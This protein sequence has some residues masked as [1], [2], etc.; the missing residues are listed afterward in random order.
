MQGLRIFSRSGEA[1]TSEEI[2]AA[3][4]I[5]NTHKEMRFGVITAED[6]VSGV[7][8][9]FHPLKRMAF[10]QPGRLSYWYPCNAVA[11]ITYRTVNAM[12][13]YTDGIPEPIPG[14][15]W[16]V[17]ITVFTSDGETLAVLPG[18]L[19]YGVA[20]TFG[21]IN[22]N[23][24]GNVPQW[25]GGGYRYAESFPASPLVI[26][27]FGFTIPE[28]IAMPPDG[29]FFLST[30]YPL[31][32]DDRAASNERLRQYILGFS[33]TTLQKLSAGEMEPHVAKAIKDAHPSLGM[34]AEMAEIITGNSSDTV[35]S[36]TIEEFYA[37]RTIQRTVNLTYLGTD[38]EQV[39]ISVT[40]TLKLETF[41]TDAMNGE[42]YFGD[43]KATYTDFP[44]F[45]EDPATPFDRTGL[46]DDDW[47]Y[48]EP[49]TAFVFGGWA[50][51][52]KYLDPDYMIQHHEATLIESRTGYP[53]MAII[54]G[55]EQDNPGSLAGGANGGTGIQYTGDYYSNIESEYLLTSQDGVLFPGG[56]RQVVKD[57][58]A[59]TNH[60]YIVAYREAY[61]VIYG[62][63]DSTL[64][65][66]LTIFG[67]SSVDQLYA[68][69][70]ASTEQEFL[71][72]LGF[73]TM[74]AAINFLMENPGGDP[75]KLD[76]G[77]LN[78]ELI[79]IYPYEGIKRDGLNYGIYS[80]QY[81]GRHLT[82][83][84]VDVIRFSKGYTFRYSFSTGEYT[85]VRVKDIVDKR[86]DPPAVA[87]QV[88]FDIS[89]LSG[90]Q[91]NEFLLRNMLVLSSRSPTKFEESNAEYRGQAQSIKDDDLFDEVE[92]TLMG[93]Y[94]F[95]S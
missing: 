82:S 61:G 83:N 40:G 6:P 74:Q 14:S 76:C 24:V 91:K 71:E 51:R 32:D 20:P 18:T 53:L 81:T 7:K 52:A 54:N 2:S 94:D 63:T 9:E 69:Y 28:D 70:G 57:E 93:L 10:T 36:E 95:L 21:S 47:L 37:E 41:A 5:S 4:K 65:Q 42:G 59:V 90:P 73:Y 50:F 60:P 45:N 78:G 30:E 17:D 84:P 33:D 55:T 86:L 77:L 80:G 25:S 62:G 75:S 88:E 16:A 67:F 26:Q 11:R 19:E 72:V 44:A 43:F 29:S 58:I 64:A 31:S 34:M 22:Y 1:L 13:I 79:T 35:I 89:E 85:F 92:L 66:V 38:G 87:E 27:F 23:Y 56:P 48:P 15:V 68:F 8:V 3:H 46:L 12:G 49:T 39:P